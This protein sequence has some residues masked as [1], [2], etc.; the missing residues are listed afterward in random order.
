MTSAWVDMRVL[1]YFPLN[2]LRTPVYL[3][4]YLDDCKTEWHITKYDDIKRVYYRIITLEEDDGFGGWV[5]HEELVGLVKEYA[6]KIHNI[7][8]LMDKI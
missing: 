6:A 3:R 5:E 1:N 7:K 8:K 2:N 4:Y